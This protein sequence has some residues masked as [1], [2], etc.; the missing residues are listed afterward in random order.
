LVLSNDFEAGRSLTLGLDYK[1]DPIRKINTIRRYKD[2]YLEFKL[3][4]VIR[5]QNENDIPISST[6]IEKI[7]IYLDQLIINYLKILI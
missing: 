6:L 2:K 1:F 4:T 3:A 7:Q 5:D